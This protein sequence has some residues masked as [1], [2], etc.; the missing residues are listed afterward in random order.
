MKTRI[1]ERRRF[2]FFALLS[3]L[4]WFAIPEA[5]ASH[6]RYGHLT[7]EARPDISPTTVEFE[8]LMA[9][10]RNGYRGSASD[11]RVQIGDIMSRFTGGLTIPRLFFGDGTSTPALDYVV[12]AYSKEENWALGAARMPGASNTG[13]I[14]TYAGPSRGDGGPWTARTRQQCRVS[15]I[16]NYS[17]WFRIESAIDLTSSERSPSSNLPS[18]VS[19]TRGEQCQFAVPVIHE[20]IDQIRWRLS[21]R[22]ESELSNQPGPPWSETPL[23]VDEVTGVVTWKTDQDTRLGLYSTAVTME[24]MDE[25]G[26]VRTSSAVEFLIRIVDETV[27]KP[28]QFD[29]P[30]TPPNLEDISVVVGQ[31]MSLHIQASDPDVNDAVT[32]NHVGLPHGAEFVAAS[33]NP[34]SGTFTWIPT[35]AQQ[36]EHLVTFTA[37][38]SRGR[39][40]LPHPIRIKVVEPGIRDVSVVAEINDE[41]SVRPDSF[42][43]EPTHM[44]QGGG[45]TRIEWFFPFLTHE[46]AESLDLAVDLDA[47]VA[48]ERRLLTRSVSL[49]YTDINGNRIRQELEPQY[50]E[51]LPSIFDVDVETERPVYGANETVDIASSLS[52]LS[53]FTADASLSLEV[54]D[55]GG[56]LVQDL[57]IHPVAELESKETR[58][59]DGFNFSTGTTY[60]GSYQVRARVLDDEQD[61]LAEAVAPFEIKVD[62]AV[63]ISGRVT[64]DRAFYDLGDAV[65]VA[66]RIGNTVSNLLAEDLH[67]E[68]TIRTPDGEVFWQEQSSLQQLPPESFRDLNFRVPLERASAGAYRVELEIF[69][70][71]G[72]LAASDATEVEVRST[73][74][75]GAG[76]AGL[77]AAFPRPVLRTENLDLLAEVLNSGNTD[78]Q[79]IPLTLS[80]VNPL[81]GVVVAEWRRQLDEL[82]LDVPYTFQ[83]SWDVLVPTAGRHYV[84][85]LSTMIGDQ[86]QTLAVAPLAVEEKLHTAIVPESR[87]RVLAL[88]DGPSSLLET[89]NSCDNPGELEFAVPSPLAL[90][91]GDQV[92]AELY[93][94]YGGLL[95]TDQGIVGAFASEWLERGREGLPLALSRLD[96][97]SIQVA[98]M[99]LDDDA[100]A[101]NVRL[102]VTVDGASGVQTFESGYL[103]PDCRIAGCW[104]RTPKAISHWLPPGRRT[105]WILTAQRM[106]PG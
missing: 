52:N 47:P 16:V 8:F 96:R 78:V 14:K 70:D 2:I 1:M 103:V 88:V 48:G 11:G 43:R 29:V 94:Q 32:L 35:E 64:T 84:A 77:L 85:I 26:V 51:V 101:G 6:F 19:C 7:W 93:D 18:I 10:R 5:E 42:A 3:A 60:S 28:P 102:A 79:N 87:G 67:V 81:D 66:D 61:A 20:D 39:A 98:L 75:S 76:V 68:T 92:T 23:T 62:D 83:Q 59:L 58:L 22:A 25:S 12:V 95:E 55:A 38:D 53:R 34:A 56:A 21:S 37:I 65:L 105:R 17:C 82:E 100:M 40:A 13:I 74:E 41:I 54:R 106:P 9:F 89:G 30:P 90:Q 50:V 49:E 104:K 33:G 46:D 63:A 24:V 69:R 80:V 57:G 44:E 27:G 4:L 36:G 99:G 97:G 71:D 72:R 91:P 15:S 73:A 45:I 31:Q 86:E